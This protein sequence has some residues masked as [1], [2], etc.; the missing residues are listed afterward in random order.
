MPDASV[1]ALA[2]VVGVGAARGLGSHIAGDLSAAAAAADQAGERQ[3]VRTALQWVVQTK[4]TEGNFSLTGDALA[5]NFFRVTVPEVIV[6]SIGVSATVV[7]PMVV[8][9]QEPLRPVEL[10]QGDHWRMRARVEGAVMNKKAR[11]ENA[12]KQPVEGALSQRPSAPPAAG[13]GSSH[14]PVFVQDALK[15]GNRVGSGQQHVPGLPQQGKT[16]RVGTDGFLAFVLVLVVEVAERGAMRK[17]ALLD[18]VA[19]AAPDIG[20][21]F[22]DHVLALAEGHLEHHHA[23]GGIVEEVGDEGQV[24][25]DAFADAHGDFRRVHLV[26][27][28]AVRVPCDD[29]V[30]FASVDEGQHSVELLPPGFFGGAAFLE[31]QDDGAASAL[32]EFLALLALALEGLGLAFVFFGGL[33]DVQGVTQRSAP[34]GGGRGG[35]V[36]HGV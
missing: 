2:V 24:F 33:A 30:D 27:G 3:S 1:F 10:V 25:E 12:A 6:S 17:P 22:G 20:G 4:N 36:W 35:F 32:G 16:L 5:E 28:E 21:Q 14:A 31:G 8:F 19:Q 29:A 15:L 9:A 7:A 26:A 34:S 18:L 11:V 13:D 23:L